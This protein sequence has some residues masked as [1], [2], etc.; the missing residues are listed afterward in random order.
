MTRIEARIASA[1]IRWQ[2]GDD[3]LSQVVTDL[4]SVVESARDDEKEQ[5]IAQACR[6]L[7][8][9]GH[10]QAA[11]FLWQSTGHKD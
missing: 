7:K 5:T 11:D 4:A 8:A 10:Q 1:L 9:A 3:D 6:E 2:D